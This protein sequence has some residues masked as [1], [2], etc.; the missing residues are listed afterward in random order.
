MTPHEIYG[1]SGADN[2]CYKQARDAKVS[3]VFRAVLTTRL[4]SISSLVF[5]K[6]QDLSIVNSKVIKS[7]FIM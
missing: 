7:I 5:Y 2:L 6:Y 3:G 4:Q 1:V